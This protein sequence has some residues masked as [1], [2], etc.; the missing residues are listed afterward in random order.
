MAHDYAHWINWD[1]KDDTLVV[2]RDGRIVGYAR[3]EW[4]DLV[5]GTRAF[6]SI[7]MLEPAQDGTGVTAAMLGWA[8]D[9]LAELGRTAAPEDP[10]P[11]RMTA[12]SFGAERELQAALEANGWSR[13]GQGHEMVRPTLDDIPE[14][15]LP[16]GLVVRPVGV[17][18]ASRRQVFEASREAFRDERDEAEGGEEEWDGFMTDPLQDPALWIV[19]FDGDE[20]AGGVLGRI[21]PGENAHHGRERGLVAAVFTRRPWRRRGLARALIARSLVRLRDHGMT[22]AY[23]GVDGLNPNQAMTLYESLG[24]E[25]ATT[26]YDWSKPLPDG[27]PTLEASVR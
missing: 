4:R 27:G 21:D 13:T 25:A 3:T 24:F 17:D 11:G 1:P 26:T 15:P 16:A 5:D 22:S 8:E 12:F 23:L 18:T 20:V 6:R 10:R 7:V 14:V 2:E 19:A 9:R